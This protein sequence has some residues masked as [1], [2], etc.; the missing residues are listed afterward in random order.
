MRINKTLSIVL[1][2]VLSIYL[3]YSTLPSLSSFE[4]LDKPGV[5]T[6]VATPPDPVVVEKFNGIDNLPLQDNTSIYQF[7]DPTSVVYMYIT[8]RKGNNSDNSDH[9]WREVNDYTKWFF[10]PL[11]VVVGKAEV[12]LQI[13]DEAGPLPGEL[14][15]AETVPNATIQIRGN[16]TSA[17]P[18]KSY[19]IELRQRA[20]EWRGQ[21]TLNLNKHIFDKTRARNKLTFDLLKQIPNM[22]SLRTQYVR[23]FVKDETTDPPKTT[24]V[25]YGLYTQIEQPNKKFLKN[26]LLDPEGQL[27]KATFFEFLRY[28]K[29]IRMMDDPLYDEAAFSRILE[30]KGNKDHTKLIQMLDDV[31]NENIPIE[32]TFE[33]HF[34]ADNYFTWLAFN[35]LMGNLDT[36][37]QNFYLYSPR[38]SNTWYFLPWD[39]DGDLFRQGR[40]F[41]GG[42]PYDEFEY[43]IANYWG[44]TLHR[45]IL[46][47][48]RYRQMLDVKVDELKSFL[49]AERIQTMLD[50]YKTITSLYS[51]AMPDQEYL[52]IS[53][54]DFNQQYEFIPGEVQIN[55]DLFKK[56]L[57]DPMPYFLTN[58]K[59]DGDSII[60]SWGESYDFNAQDI[61]YNFQISRDWAF[62]NIVYEEMVDHV[63]TV[64]VVM[65][66]PGEYFW[67]ALA[68][69]EEGKIQYPF[70]VYSDENRLPHSG[71]RHLV[72]TD[73]GRILEEK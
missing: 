42:N 56:S 59:R 29:E 52:K 9:T 58:P 36:Q 48:K 65:L 60:F 47:D 66:E 12:I 57:N 61:T 24:F 4:T 64:T 16:S 69:N 34:N 17:M 54:E 73:D 31:N 22:T 51:L 13:G 72:I 40:F 39:Y 33:K 21:T 67:R 1:T 37:A 2:A 38:N 71:M 44:V 10:G 20:G 15:Y 27:Y 53:V 23:L 14:G 35:I 62:Q 30:A 7:D 43:G 19:K 41:V 28:P 50:G 32:Q 6:L 3:L 45:R 8:V 49:T 26:H 11:Y 5:A 18:Q 25:D 63:T 68:T 70:D 46:T 55:Y